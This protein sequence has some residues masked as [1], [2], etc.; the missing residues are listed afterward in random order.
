MI[1]IA[2]GA[3]GIVAVVAHHSGPISPGGPNTNPLGATVRGELWAIERINSFQVSKASQ[4]IIEHSRSM[5]LNLTHTHTHTHKFSQKPYAQERGGV[6]CYI[7]IQTRS[8]P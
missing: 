2:L 7:K 5:P 4:P 6:I 8:L 3:E 1:R